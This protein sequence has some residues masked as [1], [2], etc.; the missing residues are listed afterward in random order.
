MPS[1]TNSLGGSGQQ[2][3]KEADCIGGSCEVRA[4]G[5]GTGHRRELG[6]S[7]GKPWV[8]PCGF[9]GSAACHGYCLGGGHVD[10]WRHRKNRI[11]RKKQ[12]NLAGKKEKKT[13]LLTPVLSYF[14]LTKAVRLGTPGVSRR[15]VRGR[16]PSVSGRPSWEDFRKDRASV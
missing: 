6:R 2:A 13:G 9:V 8:L 10:R 3:V 7:Q 12:K 11:G 14:F 1:M 5:D 16:P 15:S 4:G